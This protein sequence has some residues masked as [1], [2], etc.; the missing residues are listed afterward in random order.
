MKHVFLAIWM[1]LQN[2]FGA[3]VFLFTKLQKAKTVQ[4]KGTLVTRWK[5]GKGLSLG[6][7]IF[8]PIHASEN[9]LKHEYGHF[10]D[11]TCL[12]PLYIFVIG[13]PS[14]CWAKFGGPYRTKH[15]LSYYDFY[16]EKRADRL[17][18]VVRK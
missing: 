14:A 10:V 16:T 6:H 17:G 5:Y 3:L 18:E 11:S 7:F 15:K 2:F 9:T 13:I 8:V 1:V 4:Y 12:G